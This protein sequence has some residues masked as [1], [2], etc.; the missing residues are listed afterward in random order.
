MCVCVPSS[1]GSHHAGIWK[2]FGGY[3]QEKYLYLEIF[4]GTRKTFGDFGTKSKGYWK[5]ILGTWKAING[6]MDAI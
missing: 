4:G 3:L 1:P 6:S 5:S 2:T